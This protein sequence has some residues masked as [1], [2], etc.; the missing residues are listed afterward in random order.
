MGEP[1]I[2]IL[3]IEDNPADA[4]LLS[5]MLADRGP[6]CCTLT[7]AT[8]LGEAVDILRVDRFDIALLDLGLPDSQGLDTL[9]AVH[10]AEPEIPVIVLTILDD[11][12]FALQTVKNGAQDYLT[13]GRITGELLMRA[14]RYAIERHRL[15][16]MLHQQSLTDPLTGLNNRRGFFA[17]AEQQ[18]TMARRDK[19]GAALF[20]ADMDGLKG[21]NDRFGHAEG[22]HA[23]TEIAEILKTTCRA[24][25]LIARFGGD[26]FLVLAV[27]DTIGQGDGFVARL[28]SRFKEHNARD[29]RGYTLAATIGEIHFDP[30]AMTTLDE[31]IRQADAAMYANKERRGRA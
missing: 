5:N 30:G 16:L 31:M 29:N 17:L 27:T 15:Q 26:E 6:G 2:K 28:M 9:V 19:K 4:D 12:S 11:E 18:L 7:R 8:R 22:D 23:L 21:I 10:Q 1:A 24:S 25:D 14:M 13:K 3:L 20:F